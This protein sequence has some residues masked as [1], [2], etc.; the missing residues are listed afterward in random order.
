MKKEAENASKQE[1]VSIVKDT[2]QIPVEVS[3]KSI[4]IDNFQCAD[5]KYRNQNT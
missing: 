5:D 3:K 1:E 4:D 2:A